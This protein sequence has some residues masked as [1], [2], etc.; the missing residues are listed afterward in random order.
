M[1]ALIDMKFW[2]A[3]IFK[4]EVGRS[5]T[6]KSFLFETGVFK[7]DKMTW[8][9]DESDITPIGPNVRGTYYKEVYQVRNSPVLY[10][11]L[12]LV[13]IK[14]TAGDIDKCVVS[15][16][17]GLSP[18]CTGYPCPQE[19]L[20]GMGAQLQCW[21]RLRLDGYRPMASGMQKNLS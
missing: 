2:T 13:Q 20:P 4:L 6:S 8:I 7:A 11:T 21:T 9:V 12:P 14:G 1:Q 18:H 17:L 19:L 3:N 5:E 16:L 15:K 10:W